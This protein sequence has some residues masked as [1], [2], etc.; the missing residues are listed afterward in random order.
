MKT[1]RKQFHFMEQQFYGPT[2]KKVK[3]LETL[4][5][6]R[7]LA[8]L[9]TK[10]HLLSAEVYPIPPSSSEVYPIT[11]SSS[12]LN[13]HLEES[14]PGLSACIVS[15]N[16]KPF[17]QPHS[18]TLLSTGKE[19][20]GLPRRKEKKGK[21]LLLSNLPFQRVGIHCTPS[22]LHSFCGSTDLPQCSPW[23]TG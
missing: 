19:N 22:G 6:C 18:D 23:H 13:V 17:H 9:F 20:L 5:C 2:R 16:K 3:I 11:P 21:W 14:P 8:Q 1:S 10:A 12:L 15:F 7:E 4:L